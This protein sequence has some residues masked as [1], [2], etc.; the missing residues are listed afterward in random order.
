MPETLNIKHLFPEYVE[1]YCCQVQDYTY[2]L[3]LSELKIVSKAIDKRRFEF[4]TG[5]FCARKALDCFNHYDFVLLQEGGGAPIWPENIAGSISHSRKWAGAAVSIK[6]RVIGT[7]LDIEQI[8]RISEGV[9]NK[10]TTDIEKELLKTKKD[11]E[12]AEYTALIFSAKEAFYKALTSEY[13]STLHFTDISILPG[14]DNN[15][16]IDLN[17]ELK[18]FLKDAPAPL[19]KYMIYE[20]KIFTAITFPKSS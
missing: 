2:K 16:E 12:A 18:S 5:R 3:N 6:D 1:T 19:C 10:I 15:F 17:S 7:G 11:S 20:D 8:G 14:K 4:S 9:Q 13:K